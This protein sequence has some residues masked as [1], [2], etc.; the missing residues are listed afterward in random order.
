M[1]GGLCG[2]P[3]VPRH[4]CCPSPWPFLP[5]HA[6]M[7][8]TFPEWRP[9]VRDFATAWLFLVPIIGL[10]ALMG[11]WAGR[12]RDWLEPP[13]L[14]D[15]ARG[16]TMIGDSEWT[17]TVGQS[18]ALVLVVLAALTPL[19]LRWLAGLA[20]SV[21]T[22]FVV[23]VTAGELVD[24]PLVRAAGRDPLRRGRSRAGE[25]RLDAHPR[26]ARRPRGS[27]C[28]P[29]TGPS[30]SRAAAARSPGAG[31]L[32]DEGGRPRVPRARARPGEP[33]LVGGQHYLPDD[34]RF[35]STPTGGPGRYWELGEDA[36]C[37][38]SREWQVTGGDVLRLCL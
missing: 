14:S 4:C 33:G 34:P 17:G 2:R 20:V 24:P 29:P 7:L 9:R 36:T 6:V 23:S 11:V 21:L 18:F 26:R 16:V 32:L 25:G 1:V 37:S 12:S 35:T 38:E 22:V 5:V 31:A 19:G 13:G 28:S 15:L 8:T 10:E 30:R 3:W 27:W